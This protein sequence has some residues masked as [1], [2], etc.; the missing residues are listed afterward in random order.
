MSPHRRVLWGLAALMY[1]FMLG[2]ILITAS[3]SF[4][5]QERSYFPPR[6][7]SLHWWRAAFAPD[8]T[9]SLTFSLEL[10]AF[11]A[12]ATTLAGLP[13]ALALH[14]Y[15]F[16]GKAAVRALTFGPLVLPS[17]V[18]G[19]GLLQ[20]LT[21]AGLG[22]WIGLPALVI[23]HAVICLPF[24]VRTIGISLATIP[25][26]AERAAVSLGAGPLTVLREVTLPLARAGMGAGAIFA[27]ISS[28]DDVNLSLFVASPRQ[29]PITMKIL[30]FLEFGFSP[31]LAALSMISMLVPLVLVAVFG[32]YVGIGGFLSEHGHA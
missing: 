11:S 3:V 16:P 13:L 31:T 17:L 4:N 9:S 25:A 26:N 18:T 7:L 5:Q 2:P 14:R 23:G 1:A 24:S 28:F 6:G 32:R 20:F 21:L 27:F 22:G 12:L 19:I 30:Q 15:E 10:A 8:W 29:Q